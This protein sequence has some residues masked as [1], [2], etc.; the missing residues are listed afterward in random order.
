MKWVL[1]WLIVIVA[2]IYEAFV[3][4]WYKP[5]WKLQYCPQPNEK[6]FFNFK[7][8]ESDS[9]TQKIALITTSIRKEK[10][11][12]KNSEDAN[13]MFLQTEFVGKRTDAQKIVS[14][15]LKLYAK[16]ETTGLYD[17]EI[18]IENTYTHYK[19]NSHYYFSYGSGKKN[20]TED[21]YKII[22][23]PND[24][25]TADRINYLYIDNELTLKNYP[26]DVKAVISVKWLGGEK[27][28]TIIL[29]LIESKVGSKPRTNP[30][31]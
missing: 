24:I 30:F 25:N 28:F 16:N 31:G 29:T 22:N 21:L 20:Y 4:I 2:L 11:K 8:E 23:L 10:E 19:Y 3:F 6:M 12:D 18:N 14:V 5:K 27:D 15:Q 13:A 17:H 26:K 9:A 1:K 7:F